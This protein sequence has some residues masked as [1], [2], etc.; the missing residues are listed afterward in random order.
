MS[1]ILKLEQR[2]PSGQKL[3][4]ALCI[5]CLINSLGFKLSDMSLTNVCLPLA[6][7][8]C[9]QPVTDTIPMQ[10]VEFDYICELLPGND[11]RFANNSARIIIAS[12][13]TN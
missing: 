7:M 12:L 11:D 2:P 5:T 8:L 4:S 9:L 10:C 13:Y 3:A 1:A 6:R